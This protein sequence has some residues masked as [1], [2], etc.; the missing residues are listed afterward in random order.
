MYSFVSTSSQSIQ[1]GAV[2]I[3]AYPFSMSCFVLPYTLTSAMYAMAISRATLS[4]DW[5][6][7]GFQSTGVGLF[8]SSASG[9]SDIILLNI[10]GACLLM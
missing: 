3:T 10:R 1:L 9:S 5:F 6:A 7:L 4:A 8:Q 2:P